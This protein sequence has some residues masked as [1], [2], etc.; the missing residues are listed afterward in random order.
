MPDLRLSLIA[1]LMLCAAP[2]TAQDDTPQD[3]VPLGGVGRLAC[4][5]VTGAG[6]LPYLSQ[7]ADW[8]LGYMA[9]RLDAGQV[10]QDD[11][12][13]SPA[14]PIDL[15]TGIA[16]RCTETPDAPVID[17][18]RDI[19]AK[20][21]GDAADA[22]PVVADAPPPEPDLPEPIAPRETQAPPARPD[23]IEQTTP[24]DDTSTEQD[25]TEDT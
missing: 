4:S 23:G 16:T 1:G 10:L 24:E 19:A 6:N 22:G 25:E 20:V 9:G 18:V 8:A 12:A 17:A 2:A 15:V 11:A 14:D 21:F 5:Q 13:L 7:A 3:D